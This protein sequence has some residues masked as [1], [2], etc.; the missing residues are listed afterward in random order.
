MSSLNRLTNFYSKND[1]EN[2]KLFKKNYN[3]KLI[4]DEQFIKWFIE[5]YEH[6]YRIEG[7]IPIYAMPKKFLIAN[8]R[9]NELCRFET[10]FDKYCC[11]F[12]NSCKWN[13]YSYFTINK[14]KY[15][16]IER[17]WIMKILNKYLTVIC[18]P[19]LLTLITQYI[20]NDEHSVLDLIMYKWI[21]SNNL[22]NYIPE[23][24][25]NLY[26]LFNLKK[27]N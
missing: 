10:L 19:E 22:D 3:K 17:L 6:T 13:F 12:D 5:F 1:F 15:T 24:Y 16:I 25:S 4:Y 21:L 8:T 2:Y 23:N 27:M 9:Q 14:N 20:P 18:P 7:Y 26:Y 11:H